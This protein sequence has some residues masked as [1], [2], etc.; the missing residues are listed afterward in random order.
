MDQTTFSQTMDIDVDF[1]GNQSYQRKF[2]DQF[3]DFGLILV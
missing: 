1:D 3:V 2:N